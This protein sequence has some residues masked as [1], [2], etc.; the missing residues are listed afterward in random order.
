MSEYEKLQ[1]LKGLFSEYQTNVLEN[2]KYYNL[3]F[4][5]KVAPPPAEDGVDDL[6]PVMATTARRAIDDPAD[7]ILPTPRIKVPVRPTGRAT[8]EEQQK[9]EVKRDFLEAWWETEE[10]DYGVLASARKV[11]LNEGR[12]CIRKT[13]KWEYFPDKPGEDAT[14]AE[15]AKFRKSMAKLGDYGFLWNLELLDNL[16]VYEDTSN[17]RDP[18]YVYVEYD[19]L[20]EEAESLFGSHD[21]IPS[22]P[23][24][25]VTYTE[26]WSK[27]QVKFDGGYI[28]GKFKQFINGK[29]VHSSD[30]PYPYIP[31]AIEESGFGVS[32]NT[33]KPHERY[34]GITQH[35]HDI[36]I[37]ESRQMTTMENVAEITGFSP[38]ITRNMSPEKKIAVGPRSIIPL[39]GAKN[40]PEAEDIEAFS[41]PAV[42]ATVVQMLNKT[43][44]MAAETLKFSILGGQA[45]PGVETATEADQGLRSAAAKLQGPVLAMTRIVNK[46]SKWVLMDVDHVIKTKVTVNGTSP[47]GDSASMTISPKDIGGFYTVSSQLS[48]SD[49]DAI[50]LTKARFWLDAYKATPFLSAMTAMERGNISD[51]PMKELVKRSAEDVYL[52][53]MMRM[54]R[55]LQG[56]KY[57]G[58]L[59][60]MIQGM[61]NPEGGALPG[62]ANP[63]DQLLSQDGVDSPIQE[64]VISDAYRAREERN[65]GAY[66]A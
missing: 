43:G 4:R 49:E 25:T 35:S 24:S 46:V 8:V 28:E 39:E 58:N 45:Q 54:A 50:E 18:R 38:I 61:Q 1:N 29:E 51:E 11:L 62:Q 5:E 22:D 64:R 9:A 26:Y 60:Q 63:A 10:E 40:S 19:I 59:V 37:A 14:P 2:R 53:D 65:S 66:R 36:F 7:H 31:I 12:V 21:F 42:P 44:Q 13:L 20:A 57:F 56:G 55:V 41:W 52:S 32:Y 17:Y 34:V 27:P 16:S 23:F 47:S 15:K 6:W 30:N 3:E 48:T 33:A